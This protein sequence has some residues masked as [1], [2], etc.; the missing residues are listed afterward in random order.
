MFKI[1]FVEYKKMS[2]KYKSS[3]GTKNKEEIP[4]E[5]KIQ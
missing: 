1:L 4:A 5:N 2:Q 3:K